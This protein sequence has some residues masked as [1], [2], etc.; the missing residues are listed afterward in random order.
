MILYEFPVIAIGWKMTE[1]WRWVSIRVS[2]WWG[3]DWGWVEARKKKVF[4]GGVWRLILVDSK[5]EVSPNA[6]I[7]VT[8]NLHEE[9]LK[10]SVGIV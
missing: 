7:M 4:E 1:S 5:E 6:E 10:C 3:D 9:T 2:R 8:F